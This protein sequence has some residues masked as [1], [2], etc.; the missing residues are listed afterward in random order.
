MTYH[1]AKGLTFDSVF[2]P[3]LVG[4]SFSNHSAM[5]QLRLMF[6]ATTRAARWVLLSSVEG[7][8]AECLE[9][10]QPLVEKGVVT[11]Q[12]ARTVPPVPPPDDDPGI[13]T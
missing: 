10:L 2:L 8:E 11:N 7:Q 6:V 13:F 4:S 3:R 5:L 12:R 1:S 9:R